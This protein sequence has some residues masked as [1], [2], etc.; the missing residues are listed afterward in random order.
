MEKGDG[1]LRLRGDTRNRPNYTVEKVLNDFVDTLPPSHSP[2][3]C[4][5]IIWYH[6]AILHLGKKGLSIH[7]I[8]GRAP[9]DL[10]LNKWRR[11][12]KLR[13]GAER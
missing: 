6:P 1:G 4:F 10:L 11:M 3:T 7:G 5:L 13:S 2:L 12:R 9:V 8:Y